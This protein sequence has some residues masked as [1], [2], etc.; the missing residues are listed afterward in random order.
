MNYFPSYYLFLQESKKAIWAVL[1]ASDGE[2]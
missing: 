2:N 1:G